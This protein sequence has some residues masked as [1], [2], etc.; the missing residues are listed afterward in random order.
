MPLG[1]ITFRIHEDRDIGDYM[2]RPWRSILVNND[3]VR[4]SWRG[5][6]SFDQPQRSAHE[7]PKSFPV[8]AV[9]RP[10]VR[11]H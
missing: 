7:R 10:T 1:A 8:A 11:K 4:R 3:I 9:Y 6:L 5:R 2:L